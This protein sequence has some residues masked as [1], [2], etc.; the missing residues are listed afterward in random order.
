MSVVREVC[1][2]HADEDVRGVPTDY[3][4]GSVTFTCERRGHPDGPHTWL[5]VPA[6]D[7]GPG[8]SGL[9]AELGLATELPAA[10]KA[11]AGRWVEYGLVER[12]YAMRR[13]DDFARLVGRFGHTALK[14]KRN[15]ASA[16]LAGYLASL[17]KRGD[18]L[19]HDGP[20]TGRWSYN[21]KISWW[22]VVPRPDWDEDRLS[23]AA[24]AYVVDYVPG[25]AATNDAQAP[26]ARR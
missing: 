24:S 11:F 7:V 6:V 18:I 9:A 25:V 14:D 1:P 2:F 23:W 21:S 15:T 3:G 5:R 8:G 19:Y 12:A 4:D 26:Y 20:A 22:A 16:F 10:I 17:A 13:P